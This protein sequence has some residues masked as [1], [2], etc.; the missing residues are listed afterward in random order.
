VFGT[1]KKIK[2]LDL[3]CF[4]GNAGGRLK[5]IKRTRYFKTNDADSEGKNKKLDFR[6]E[7]YYI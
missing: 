3:A 1:R 5:K 7:I 2:G 4:L 6:S